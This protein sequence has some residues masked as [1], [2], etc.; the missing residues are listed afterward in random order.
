MQAEKRSGKK[1]IIVLALIALT[2]IA[3]W[4]VKDN[5]FVSYDDETYVVG[6]A[7]V[8]GGLVNAPWALTATSAANW[9]PLTWLS[10]ML[11]W[12]LFGANPAGHHVVSLL[13]HASSVVVLFWML[14]LMTGAVWRSALAA[15]LFAVHPINVESVAWIAER[16]NVLSTLFWLLTIC[17]YVW[18]ARKPGWRRYSV[19]VVSFVAGLLSKPMLVTLPF[20][21]ML[22][23]YWPLGRIDRWQAAPV[24]AKKQKKRIKTDDARIFQITSLRNAIIEKVPLLLLCVA[25]SVITLKAQQAGGAVGSTETFPLVVRFQNAIVSYARYLL[26]MVWPFQLGVFYPHPRA[27]LPAWQ[28]ALAAIVLLAVTALSFRFAKRFRYAPVGWLWYLGTLVPVIGIVQ[29]GLQS[30]ADR[31]A[32]IPLIG[33]FTAIAWLSNDWAGGRPLRERNLAV[34]AALVLIALT[35]GTRYQASTWRNSATLFERAIAVTSNNYVAHNNLGELLARQGKLDEATTQ[36]QASLDANPDFSQARQNMGMI[37]IKQGK[38]Q[39]AIAEFTMAVESNPRSVDAYNKLGAALASVGRIDEAVDK[40]SR[41]LEIDPG[42]GS[43]RA[44][45]GSAYEQLGRTD[46][47]IAAYTIALQSISDTTMSAQ[48]HFKLG[49]L[50]TKNG[51]TDEAIEHLRES[52]RLKPDYAPAQQALLKI[53]Q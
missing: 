13:I 7:Q 43:A 5:G 27:A 34:A 52:L 28:L 50:L 26:D 2:L 11:D 18:Y 42:Y 33:I 36:F 23:D 30:R 12:Q 10:H 16:K 6:N 39:E 47:A 17:A 4:G 32:Y 1:R 19:V 22:L 25:S 40:F 53:A 45:L 3:Y 37:L 51:R 15:A 35:I 46:E 48:T 31:Y 49:Q 24:A 8:R 41:A 14:H 44:N 20:A 9:H 38:P 29:V 21:L